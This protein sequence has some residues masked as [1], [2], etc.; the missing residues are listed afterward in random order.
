MRQYRYVKI[1]LNRK[2]KPIGPKNRKVV[3]NLHT[4]W[5]DRDKGSR[6]KDNRDKDDRDKDDRDKDDRDK[7][8]RDNL[9]EQDLT[10]TDNNIKK[11]RIIYIHYIRDINY[12]VQISI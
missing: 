2:L 4:C 10:L 12:I 11:I 3:T 1:M 8:N 5:D 7:D 9:T 6:D